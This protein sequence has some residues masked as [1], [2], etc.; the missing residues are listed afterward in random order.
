MRLLSLAV[1]VLLACFCPITPTL[2]LPL[3]AFLDFYEPT[4]TRARYPFDAFSIRLSISDKESY[5]FN[6]I[7]SDIRRS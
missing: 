4:L 5:Y 7:D 1:T 3:Y 2:P 6:S